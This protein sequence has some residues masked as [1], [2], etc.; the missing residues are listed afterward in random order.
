[1]IFAQFQVHFRYRAVMDISV[2]R[3]SDTGDKSDLGM[4]GLSLKTQ[5]VLCPRT[6]RGDAL[7]LFQFDGAFPF[8]DPA[9]GSVLPRDLPDFAENFPNSEWKIKKLIGVQNHALSQIS[10]LGKSFK[11]CIHP[12]PSQLVIIPT[13]HPED[14]TIAW[15][16]A[17]FI[18]R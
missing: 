17:L 4:V 6:G 3:D 16:T 13:S 2:G 8:H 14:E 1:V 10:F 11:G 5:T 7:Y 18:P 15:G 12:L 9:I